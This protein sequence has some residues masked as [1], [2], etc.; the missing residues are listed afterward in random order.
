MRLYCHV[1][2]KVQAF[3]AISEDA[4][5][6]QKCNHQ[7]AVIRMPRKAKGSLTNSEKFTPSKTLGEHAIGAIGGIAQKTRESG[8]QAAKV[9]SSSAATLNN[10][11]QSI[12]N[13]V[14]NAKSIGHNIT[15]AAN[16]VR[17]TQISPDS[18][19]HGVPIAQFDLAGAMG[20]DLYSSES[21]IPEMGIV[22]ATKH[23]TKIA[24]QSNSLDVGIAK[25]QR[26]RKA[27]KLATELSLLQGD[28]IDYHTVGVNNSTKA[29]KN[30]IAH[31]DYDIEYSKLS[32][33][34]ALLDQQQIKTGAAQAMTP[35]LAEFWQMKVQQQEVANQ[36]LAVDIEKGLADVGTKRLELEAKL[37]EASGL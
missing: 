11:A 15:G 29:V 26:D 24:R 17:G 1:C 18:V 20:G 32:E 14:S 22:E 13:G 36:S 8:S 10:A 2:G 37:I 12:Q 7:Q 34:D 19:P 31:R 33:K 16:A 28:A 21:S 30:E 27:L 4:I 6:C 9:V 3:T 35:L 25:T 23:R 5:A